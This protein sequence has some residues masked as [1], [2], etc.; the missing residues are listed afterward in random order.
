MLS[1]T[2]IARED[3][4]IQRFKERLTVL[5]RTDTNDDLKLKSMR[6]YHSEN[7]EAPQNYTKLSLP[8]F[9]K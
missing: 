7:L 5:L 8:V 2:F 9:Y 4:C 1:R 6:N 3:V